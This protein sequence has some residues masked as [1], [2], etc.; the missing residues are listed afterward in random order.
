MG[1]KTLTAHTTRPAPAGKRLR[2]PAHH[3]TACT[4]RER[5][6]NSTGLPDTLIR[7][8]W[9]HSRHQALMARV[10][11]LVLLAI[12]LLAAGAHSRSLRGQSGFWCFLLPCMQALHMCD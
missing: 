11:R 4:V 7:N 9:H 1:G 8:P 5:V 6:S 3:T 12:V 2:Q 10:T